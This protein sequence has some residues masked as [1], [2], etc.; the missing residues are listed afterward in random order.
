MTGSGRPVS[1]MIALDDYSH[2]KTRICQY[3]AYKDRRAVEIAKQFVLAKIEAQN[4]MLRKHKLIPFETLNIPRKEQIARIYAEKIDKIRNKLHTIEANYSQHYFS[5]IITLFPKQLRKNWKKRE[6]Y[7]AYDELNNLFNFAYE[8][9]KWTIFRALIKA[10]LEPYLGFLHSIQRTRAS[11]V[12]DFQEIYRCLIDDFLIKYSQKLK[13]KDFEKHYEKGH[14]TKKIPRI[15]LTHSETNNLVNHLN[16]YFETK[17]DIQ[18]MRKRGK[19]QT[20]ETLINEEARLFGMYLRNERNE[21]IPRIKI[22]Y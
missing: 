3:E 5:Q 17:I 2:V 6:G 22:P 15:Y 13:K 10:K 8:F 7:R 16:K 9:L 12:C 14:Y 1:T 4:Q 18:T 20:L 21:W 11:L 19:K